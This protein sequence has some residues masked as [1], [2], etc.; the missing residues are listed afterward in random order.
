MLSYVFFSN[1]RKY[2]QA[3]YCRLCQYVSLAA[4]PWSHGSNPSSEV[5]MLGVRNKPGPIKRTSKHPC[6]LKM[7]FS[8]D[9]FVEFTPGRRCRQGSFRKVSPLGASVGR[10]ENAN[11]RYREDEM[12]SIEMKVSNRNA[13]RSR[14]F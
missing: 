7:S 12:G 4:L 13:R 5:A 14:P 11:C 6:E 9:S 8:G 10:R 2:H 1:A 3:E